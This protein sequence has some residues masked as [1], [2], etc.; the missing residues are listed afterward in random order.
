MTT[1]GN[2]E[3]SAKPT[4][5]RG[6]LKYVPMFRDHVFVL[7]VDGSLVAHENFQNVLLDIAVLRSLHIKVILVHGIGQQ[8]Q[9]LAE[10]KAIRITDAHGELDT[11]PATLDLATEAAA[12]VSLQVMQGLTRNGLRCATC[13]G[14]RGKEIGIVRGIDQGSTGAV[15]KLDEVLFNKLLDAGT[16]PVVT[17]I[18]LNREGTPLRINS[19]L[20]AS[21]LAS[22]LSASKLIF[23]TAQNGLSIDGQPMTNLPVAELEALLESSPEKVPERLR[24]KAQHAVKV[25][26]AG[27]PR[28][29][30]LD[31]R[32]FGALLNEIF[33]KVGIGTMVY[34][35]DYQSIRRATPGDAHAIYNI[36]RNGVRSESLRERPLESIESAIND[37]LVYE[38]DGSLVA[39]VHLQSYDAEKLIEVGSVYVQP[40]YQ[41]RGV[42]RK[43]VEFACAEAK[44]RGCRRVIA[45]TTQASQFFSKVCAFTEGGVDDLPKAR[46]DEYIRNGRNSKVLYL[47]L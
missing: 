10:D 14:V 32:L 4:D 42:G 27:T 40:F 38:I 9:A 34:S 11:D 47:D 44:D 16:I 45:L 30:I 31:G 12:M 20:L 2:N 35:N 24:S 1:N 8:L 26:Q 36:T 33:D 22:R 7:A 18:A 29:H 28:A 3:S 25:I 13:N 39:C 23:L 19:D 43:M 37:Y 17:P 46:R 6:I 41:N 21:E 5:L 15:D